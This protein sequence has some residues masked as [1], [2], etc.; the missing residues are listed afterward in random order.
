MPRPALFSENH[1]SVDNFG[2]FV[3]TQRQLASDEQLDVFNEVCDRSHWE[4]HKDDGRCSIH[5][6]PI[7]ERLCQW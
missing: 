3:E 7:G 1:H 4:A 2:P 6:A 5:V